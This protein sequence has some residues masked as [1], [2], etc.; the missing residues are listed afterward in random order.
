[1]WNGTMF[2]D[3]DWP[4][5]ASSLLSASAELLVL[6]EADT[7]TRNQ[8]A[9]SVLHKG[10]MTQ[11]YQAI[12][13]AELQGRGARAR[14]ARETQRQR[15]YRNISRINNKPTDCL[16][17]PNSS[18]TP[19][20]IDYINNSLLHFHKNRWWMPSVITIKSAMQFT[21]CSAFSHTCFSTVNR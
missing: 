18:H 16:P 10:Q 6:F 20:C 12:I 2:V 14:T 17:K 9:D 1:M 3:L 21:F 13:I 7:I 4:L 15:E 11:R 19:P 5:N 8:L